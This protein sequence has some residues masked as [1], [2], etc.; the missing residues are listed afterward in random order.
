MVL[1][2][3]RELYR[4]V[5]CQRFLWWSST[6]S[7]YVANTKLQ[8]FSCCTC[9]QHLQCCS[10]SSPGYELWHQAVCL[11]SNV[12][13]PSFSFV[14]QSGNTVASSGCG[15]EDF[16]H[17]IV[18]VSLCFFWT[19]TFEACDPALPS[20]SKSGWASY[21]IQVVQRLLCV[22]SLQSGRLM[23]TKQMKLWA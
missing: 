22:T 23:E 10:M 13:T 16:S 9:K 4:E 8:L 2:V 11:P 15:R 20:L 19:Q 7:S 14:W 12:T 6:G 5:G 17:Y 21:T 1:S 18:S 3:L